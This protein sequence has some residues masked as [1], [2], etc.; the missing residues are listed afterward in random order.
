MNCPSCKGK[1][2]YLLQVDSMPNPYPVKCDYCNGTGKVNRSL[3]YKWFS[4]R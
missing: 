3:F 1:G 2:E 4:R